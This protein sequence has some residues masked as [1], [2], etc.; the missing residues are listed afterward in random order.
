MWPEMQQRTAALLAAMREHE[1]LC[2]DAAPDLP[3]LARVRWRIADASRQ[4]M[5][6][7]I[8]EVLPQAERLATGEAAR[9]LRRL[10]DT[11]PS[12][13]QRISAFNAQWSAETLATNWPEY[14]VRAGEIRAAIRA[15]LAEEAMVIRLLSEERNSTP[16]TEPTARR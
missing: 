9:R 8:E 3:A 1:V 16:V 7:L 2:R 13:R 11:T 4:R 15:R 6:Y 12:Y 10:K 14:R 5:E